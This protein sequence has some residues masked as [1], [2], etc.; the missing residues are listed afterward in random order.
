M[1]LIHEMRT[2]EEEEK[3]IK[4]ARDIAKLR[5]ALKDFPLSGEE[6]DWDNDNYYKAEDEYY[7]EQYLNSFNKTKVSS[8]R[9]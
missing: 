7:R 8:V 4:R 2:F 3:I 9:N 6:K 1:G 5:V